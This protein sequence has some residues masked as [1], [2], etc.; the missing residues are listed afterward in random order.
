VDGRGKEQEE[1]PIAVLKPGET[2]AVTLSAK[3]GK[4]GLR[5]LTATV[6]QDDLDADNRFDQVI[7]VR[8]QVRVL[9][10]D[11]ARDEREPDR[12]AAYYLE[13]ALA[14][15][16]DE[17][18][19]KYH[20]RITSLTPR[21]VSG[22]ELAKYDVCILVN[23]GWS[24][25]RRE[26][27]YRR[28]TSSISSGRS[29][30]RGGGL[31][32]FGGDNVAPA[33]YNRVLGKQLG[34]LP[35]QI[36]GVASFPEDKAIQPDRNSIDARRCCASREDE[37]YKDLG[38]VDVLR[39]LDLEEPVKDAKDDNEAEREVVRVLMRYTNGKPA[40]ASRK[41]D[42]GEVLLFGT[43]RRRGGSRRR[44]RRRGTGWRCGPVMCPSSRRR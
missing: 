44:A 43:R 34:L 28:R 37:D 12:S 39:T 7:Q 40:L 33:A 42:A 17:L 6:K 21:Q 38:G 19:P 22:A 20:V 23:V 27:R 13:H 25:A 1:Q 11:G 41:V 16:K 14:P 32:V 30:R 3:L 35:L 2:R 10:V 8:D 36:A 31:I 18:K 26:S 4:A 24:A 15:V 29:L 9:V 5:V